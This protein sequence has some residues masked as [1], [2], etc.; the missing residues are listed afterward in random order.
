VTE[1]TLHPRRLAEWHERLLAYLADVMPLVILFVV[2]ALFD[3]DSGAY[4]SRDGGSASGFS[5]QVTGLPAVFLFAVT[6]GWFVYNWLLRQGTTGQTMGKK[7]VG[8]AVLD[9]SQRP[10]GAGLT[11]VRQLAHVLDFLPCFLGYLWPVWDPE[12]R[13]FADMI[14]GTRVHRIGPGRL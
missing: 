3:D 5:L 1:R 13:T 7:L 6:I 12:K 2:L 10:I 8:I 14:M 4:S 11:F 9:G